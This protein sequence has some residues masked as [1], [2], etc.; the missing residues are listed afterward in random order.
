MRVGIGAK[1]F[2]VDALVPILQ[3]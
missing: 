1:Y 2:T 3:F